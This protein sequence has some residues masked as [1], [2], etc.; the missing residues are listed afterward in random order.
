MLTIENK[1]GRKNFEKVKRIVSRMKAECFG[2]SFTFLTE[3][4]K[5]FSQEEASFFGK[6]IKFDIPV[7][8][9]YIQVGYVAPCA[10]T[11][12]REVWKGRKW[13]LSSHM[14][15][16]EIVKTCY[17]AF[18][19]CVEHEVMEGFKVDGKVLFNPHINFEKLLEISEFEVKREDNG[20]ISA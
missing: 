16:D 17:A 19:A 20:S 8:R 12:K 7:G 6:K 10:K 3:F 18:K 14:T 1:E 2:T 11:G 9:I 5:S 4:D 13:Y 15:D